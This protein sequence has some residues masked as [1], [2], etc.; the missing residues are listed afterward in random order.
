[1]HAK[2]MGT[3][4]A[5]DGGVPESPVG[6]MEDLGPA[7]IPEIDPRG[8]YH[9]PEVRRPTYRETRSNCHSLPSQDD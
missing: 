9:F 8:P 3:R 4:G 5:R 1:M 7:R 2:A 6:M